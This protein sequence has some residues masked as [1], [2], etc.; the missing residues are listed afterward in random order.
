V[1]SHRVTASRRLHLSEP[2]RLDLADPPTLRQLWELQRAAYAVEAEIIGF[3]GIPPLQE[4][5]QQ[6]RGCGE[7]FL[8]VSDE[9]GLVGAVSWTR[10]H[11]GALEICR[12]V[13]D[14][15]VHR[16]GIASAL[17]NRLDALE[18]ADVTVVS[19]GSAN[20]PALALYRSRGFIPTGER[21]VAPEVRVTL[22]ER[23]IVSPDCYSTNRELRRG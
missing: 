2:H 12:L 14:P 7:S 6:L 23:K 17:L 16:C 5:L 1:T 8:G 18:P 3:D 13:V 15:R 10:L 4:T 21:H 20:Y 19:T 22:L 9:T 11:D